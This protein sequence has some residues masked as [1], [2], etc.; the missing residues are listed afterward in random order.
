MMTGTDLSA[1]SLA[2][3]RPSGAEV[4]ALRG[5]DFGLMAVLAVAPMFMGGRHPMGELVYMACVLWTAACTCAARMLSANPTWRKSG[6]ELLMALGLAVVVIQIIPLSVEWLAKLSPAIS[7]FLPLWFPEGAESPWGSWSTLS[8]MPDATWAALSVYISHVLLFVVVMQRLNDLDDIEQLLRWMACA[9]V[10]MAVLAIVQLLAGNGKFL[11]VYQHP[12]RDT[13]RAAKG[14]FANE[15]HFGHYLALGLGPLLWWLARAS[16]V[17]ASSRSETSR[18]SSR[19]SSRTHSLRSARASHSGGSS[20]TDRLRFVLALGIAIVMF[21]GL[22]TFSRGGVIALFVTMVVCV[23]I[24]AQRQVLE[25]KTILVLGG[26]GLLVGLSLIIFG[27]DALSKQLA[28]LGAG[29]LEDLDGNASR[30]KLWEADLVGVRHFPIFG[31]GGGTHREVYPTFFSHYSPTEFSHAESGYL[32]ILLEYGM[33]GAGLLLLTIGTAGTW[34]YRALTRATSRR[35]AACAGA[36]IAG[37]AANLTQSIWD[38]VWFLPT[39]MTLTILLG[40][41]ACRLSQIATTSTEA[42]AAPARR[43]L[44]PTGAGRLLWGGALAGIVGL[45]VLFVPQSVGVANGGV[46]WDSYLALSGEIKLNPDTAHLIET[47]DEQLKLLQE[48]LRQDPGHARAHL[49]ISA[50]YLQRFDIMQLASDNPMPI[51]QVR[52]VV[53]ISQFENAEKRDAWLQ[54]AVGE[55]LENLK[56]ANHHINQALRHCA[57][58]GEGYVYLTEL[59]F[60]K[61]D[62]LSNDQLISQAMQ[63]RPYRGAVLLAAGTNAVQKGDRDLALEYWRK[64]FHSD[65][66]HQ[67]RLVQLLT[68]KFPAKFLWMEFRPDATA[69]RKI[70]RAYQKLGRNDQALAMSAPYAQLLEREAATLTGTDAAALWNEIYAVYRLRDDDTRSLAAIQQAVETDPQN[71]QYRRAY[72]HEFLRQEQYENA[73]EQFQWCLYRRPHDT[74]LDAL[75][76]RAKRQAIRQPSTSHSPTPIANLPEPRHQ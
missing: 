67:D 24:Y 7:R 30:R 18:H 13:F 26:V 11:W 62:H 34:C 44:V 15:N 75:M 6:I 70:F 10:A 71:F 57:F 50:I 54:A 74:Q 16:S 12:T 55:N 43:S 35:T 39:C 2:S 20:Q 40:A 38:F 3:P 45:G 56:L 28:T 59:D 72:G 31:T 73:A 19:S 64:A 76:T 69:A 63:V 36:V 51:D 52:E 46:E 14:V 17:G 66:E 5:V 58:Q 41:C 33:L 37:L 8:L 49:T 65:P 1:H 68:P 25:R 53:S 47:N 9:V 60:F 22:L 42:S 61:N 48:T 21:A 23:A 29:S 4:I 32:Q 27:Q